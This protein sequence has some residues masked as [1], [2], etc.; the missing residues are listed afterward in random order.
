MFRYLGS[1]VWPLKDR[2]MLV[3]FRTGNKRGIT[4]MKVLVSE[5]R[6]YCL[7]CP[8]NTEC[9]VVCSDLEE[10][11]KLR[12]EVKKEFGIGSCFLHITP[13]KIGRLRAKWTPKF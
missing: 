10:I 9:E 6:H 1:R 2:V 13:L 5:D 12:E 4:K 8:Y 11:G 7:R 3:Y